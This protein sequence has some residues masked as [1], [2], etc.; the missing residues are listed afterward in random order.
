MGLTI[1][2]KRITASSRD[3]SK[4]LMNEVTNAAVEGVKE[5]LEKELKGIECE[6]HKDCTS[7]TITI[8]GKRNGKRIAIEYSN[9]CCTD[10][11]SSLDL[12]I[13]S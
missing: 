3:W 10:F 4:E 2:S 13:A 12:Q 9:F 6:V 11:K 1:K 5:Q 8:V 7:G